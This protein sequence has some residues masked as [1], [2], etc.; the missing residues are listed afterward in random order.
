VLSKGQMNLQSVIAGDR[1]Y[2][3]GTASRRVGRG[4]VISFVS[5]YFLSRLAF[6]ACEPF[7][8]ALMS[9]DA[10]EGC[11]YYASQRSSDLDLNGP[12]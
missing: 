10:E 5:V 6:S 3:N 8:T 11:P 9:V 12:R 7:P 1:Q 4:L 2:G